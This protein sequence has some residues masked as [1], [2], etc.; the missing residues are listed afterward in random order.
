[1]VSGCHPPEPS[2]RAL[3]VD[4][5]ACHN[6]KKGKDTALCAVLYELAPKAASGRSGLERGRQA[7][8]PPL[9]SVQCTEAGL[10]VT[11]THLTA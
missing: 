2:Q 3:Q 10:F 5:Q 9:W 1:M 11:V 6:S 4:D 7:W 8:W